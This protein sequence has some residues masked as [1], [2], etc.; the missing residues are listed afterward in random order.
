MIEFHKVELCDK[1]WIK[2]KL[3]VK[4]SISC[5]Y[6][7][8]NLFMYAISYNFYVADCFDC[9]V[10]K[11]VLDETDYYYFPVGNG[12]INAALNAILQEAAQSNRQAVLGEMNKA[13]LELLKALNPSV[14]EPKEN[15]DY[16]DYVYLTEDLINLSGKKYQPKR[17]HIHFFLRNNL[18]SY[19]RITKE[20]IGEC[21]E[22]SEEWLKTRPLEHREE[23]SEELRLIKRA[24]EYY[25][26]LD[27]VGG[28][29]RADGRV[30]AY[31]MGERLN[32]DTFCIHFEKAFADIR[33]AS[34]MINRQ[35]AENELKDYKY[36]NREDDVGTE[37]LRQAKLSY[38]P[39]F[40][41]EKYETRIN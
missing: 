39:V 20:S 10:I 30:V 25:E 41:V 17:N 37:N 34:Q 5:E 3:K 28:L 29:I 32:E 38:N 35:F 7:F 27:F 18:W 21:L 16:F 26:E 36:I 1:D 40:L 24:F 11:I 31:T 2:E 15:R 33:G 4:K 13:D 14:F 6:S 8:G 9:L 23:L 22:M 12:D 19:E